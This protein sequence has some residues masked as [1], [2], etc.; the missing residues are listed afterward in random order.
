MP[1]TIKV[2]PSGV[3]SL[4]FMDEMTMIRKKDEIVFQAVLHLT[5][6][7]FYIYERGYI[8]LPAYK[9]VYFICYAVAAGFINYFLMPRYLYRQKF[10]LFGLGLVIVFATVMAGEELVLEYM[11]F[12]LERAPLFPGVY[13][14]LLEIL[15]TIAILSGFKFAWDAI[16]KQVELQGIKR[17]M[18][19]GELQFLKSQINPHFLFNNLNNLYSHSLRRSPKTPEIILEMS[20]LLRYMLYECKEQF[21]SLEKEMEQ[22]QN[23]V[24]LSELQVETRGCVAFETSELQPGYKIAPLILLVFV[25]NAFKHAQALQTKDIE[26]RVKISQEGTILRFYSGNNYIPSSRSSM[27]GHGIGLENVKK[28]LDYLYPN[29]H[30]LSITSNK[31]WYEVNLTLELEKN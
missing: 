13:F 22:L 23:F 30:R 25:E 14:T 26:I 21:V 12:P 20:G 3:Y 16:Q 11:F 15:P 17:D 6:F 31:Q 7:V 24:K 9:I 10:L 18:E 19:E 8:A 28:R 2:F 4:T 1:F 27:N 29:A 5:V